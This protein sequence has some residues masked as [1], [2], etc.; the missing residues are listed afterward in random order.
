MKTNIII[1][2]YYFLSTLV[3]DTLFMTLLHNDNQPVT[4]NFTFIFRQAFC[5]SI[6]WLFFI[7]VSSCWTSTDCKF[8]V[9][10]VIFI[11]WILFSCLFFSFPS[12]HTC[13]SL[14][15]LLS[16]PIVVYSPRV[17]PVYVYDAHADCGKNVRFV[18]CSLLFFHLFMDFL[19]F[20]HLFSIIIFY[21]HISALY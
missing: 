11:P 12:L 19:F 16:P 14:Q 10:I 5:G 17:L 1:D 9:L 2:P 18:I 3:L 8:H 21:I 20:C 15:V 6:C 4:L 13:V 7:S